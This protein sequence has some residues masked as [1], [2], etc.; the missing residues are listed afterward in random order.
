MKRLLT[1]NVMTKHFQCHRIC[2]WHNQRIL[3]ECYTVSE[4]KHTLHMARRSH[5]DRPHG[6]SIWGSFEVLLRW[7]EILH[8][9]SPTHKFPIIR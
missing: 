9:L 4:E 6:K 2:H 1:L 3:V 8:V 5:R 7:Q